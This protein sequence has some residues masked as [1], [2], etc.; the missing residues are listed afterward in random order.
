MNHL[1]SLVRKL[2][3]AEIPGDNANV[4]GYWARVANLS[5]EHGSKLGG[6]VLEFRQGWLQA[7]LELAE[8]RAK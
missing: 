6:Y 8:E 5:I 2:T 7:D 3:G 4:L 1:L